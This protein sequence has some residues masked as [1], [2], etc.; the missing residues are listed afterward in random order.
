MDFFSKNG[1]KLGGAKW[2]RSPEK[3]QLFQKVGSK[4]EK[5][6]TE[7][8]F[9]YVYILLDSQNRIIDFLKKKKF[10]SKKSAIFQK[11]ERNYPWQIGS[12]LRKKCDFFKKS[13]LKG[14][15]GVFRKN[16]LT[17]IYNEIVRIG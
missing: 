12:G 7:P 6:V 1:L 4:W 3:I 16:F 8:F 14:S 2:S 11:S 5:S 13:N 9:P 10:L 15:Y 17:S